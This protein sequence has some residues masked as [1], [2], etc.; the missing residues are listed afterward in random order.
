MT[1]SFYYFFSSTPQVLGGVLALFGVF[2]IFKIQ[3]IRSQLIGLARTMLQ[4]Y[5]ILEAL[6]K[7]DI[8]ELKSAVELNYNENKDAVEYQK[9]NRLFLSLKSLIRST[10]KWS[11]F[12]AIIIIFCLIMLTMGCVILKNIFF[13]YTLFFIVITCVI[14]CFFSL[15]SILKKAIDINV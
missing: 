4:E 15:V 13:L 9:F 3:S 14:I 12:T 5:H 10:I 1:N 2:V 8:L 7:D 6:R 11:I